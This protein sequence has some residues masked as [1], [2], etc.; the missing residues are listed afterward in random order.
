[1]FKRGKE[2]VEIGD[3]FVKT[4]DPT[5]VWKVA[6]P[7]SSVVKIPHFQ[8]V[9]EDSENRIRTLSAEVLLDQAYYQRVNK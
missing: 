7:G 4:D 6:G 5:T 1:M 3:R 9:R 2:T 8:V